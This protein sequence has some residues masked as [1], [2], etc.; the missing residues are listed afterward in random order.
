MLL[1]ESSLFVYCRRKDY[2]ICN[3]TLWDA[4]EGGK[5]KKG[6]VAFGDGWWERDTGTGTTVKDYN[7]N[8]LSVTQIVN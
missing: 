4:T 7:E 5:S 2:I 6:E 8:K 1:A 3:E